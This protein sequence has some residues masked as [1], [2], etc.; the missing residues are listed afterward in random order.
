VWGAGVGPTSTRSRCQPSKS[1][2]RFRV[3][4]VR[5]AS[6]RVGSAGTA[7]RLQVCGS[8]MQGSTRTPPKGFRLSL[9]FFFNPGQPGH[10]RPGEPATGQA[11]HLAGRGRGQPVPAAV[12]FSLVE[13]CLHFRDQ[14]PPGK[15]SGMSSPLPG[16]PPAGALSGPKGRRML[17]IP[18]KGPTSCR[19][20]QPSSPGCGGR[21]FFTP[22]GA[23]CLDPGKIRRGYVQEC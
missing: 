19:P 4:R 6:G 7:T 17:E 12:P 11:V 15:S 21:A 13:G 1:C 18:G 2:G 22:P 3:K 16:H 5:S 14:T 8:A 23:D 10:D 20:P 9:R